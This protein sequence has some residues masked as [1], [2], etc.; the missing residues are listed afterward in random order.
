M[1]GPASEEHAPEIFHPNL[2]LLSKDVR[3]PVPLTAN[4]RRLFQG[5]VR[6]LLNQGQAAPE[7]VEPAATSGGGLIHACQEF[8]LGANRLVTAPRGE[9]PGAVR[10]MLW[11]CKDIQGAKNAIYSLEQSCPG[12]PATRSAEGFSR[13]KDYMAVLEPRLE[14]LGFPVRM[15]LDRFGIL[16]VHLDEAYDQ[17]ALQL[18]LFYKA[19]ARRSEL[20]QF[21]RFARGFA[22]SLGREV[23]PDLVLG[24]GAG[25]GK[26]RTGLMELLPELEVEFE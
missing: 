2:E 6:L 8:I 17:I 14:E 24:L 25:P 3:A 18:Q 4:S 16:Q 21:Q 7:V 20:A 11:A 15:D 9:L 22:L 19:V 13:M 10:A 5:T 26:E 23:I 12:G 1:V